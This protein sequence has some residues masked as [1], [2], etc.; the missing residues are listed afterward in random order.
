MLHSPSSP[1]KISM[2]GLCLLLL[3]LGSVAAYITYATAVRGQT[4]PPTIT[5]EN[6]P[7]TTGG[8]P[9]A[10]DIEARIDKLMAAMTIE[11]LVGQTIQA[12]ISDVTPADVRQYRLGAILNG[13]NSAP[14][15]DVRASADAWLALADEFYTASMDTTNGG[16]AIPILWGT[17]A[18]HGHNNIVGATVF[19]H[20]IGLGATRNP[21]LI[22]QIGEITAR[23]VIVT[24]MDWTFAPTLAVVRD[25]RW[26]RTYESYSEDPEIVAQYAAAM[27]TG[28][29]GELHTHSFLSNQHVIA[30]AKH[31]I[32][33]GGTQRGKD[34]GDNIDSETAL[35]DHHGAGYPPA[36]AAGVQTVM[37]SFSSWHGT[38]M[39]GHKAL[40]TDVLK[41]RMGFN[42]FVVGDWNGHAQI[43][44]CSTKSCPTAFNA[45]IDMFMAPDSWRELH[46]NT[47][48]QV[49]SGEIPRSRLDDAVR[50]IL[51]VKLRFL[52]E[53][54]KPS[55]R[56][57]AGNYS[58]LG[59]PNHQ[60]VARQAV[61]ESLVLLKNQG[62]LLP[63]PT[64]QT[65]LVTG[66][67]AHNIGK[68]SGGWTL[69]W[70]GTGNTNEHFPNG[71]S[72][73]EG[74]QNAIE[75]GG[76]QAVLS[77]DG[78]YDQTPDVAIVVFGEEPYAEFK[79]DLE[80]LNY[81]SDQALQLLQSFQAQ[82]IPTVAVFL[83]GRPLWVTPEI[84]AAD[85]FVAAWLPGS[86]GAG[87]ADVLLRKPNGAINVDFKGKLS[88]SWPRTATQTKVNQS[89]NYDP[90]FPYGYGLTYEDNGNVAKLPETSGLD[91]SET[92]ASNALF[93]FGKPMAPWSLQ[94]TVGDT[95]S[96]VVDARTQ[97]GKTLTIRAIDRAAQEDAQQFVWSGAG[98]I[99]LTGP[100]TDYTAA[101]HY[102]DMA[103]A[104]QYRVDALPAGPVT[105][106]A[107]SSDGCQADLDMTQ[108]FTKAPLGEW[109]QTEIT[110]SSLVEAGANMAQLTALGIKTAD[111]F[112]LSLSDIRLV[113]RD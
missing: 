5:P 67:G 62:N 40:L 2:L 26:G 68:Q 24:G 113:E 13:G 34:Q 50:R 69:S 29:Q 60:A 19:P 70:Q 77:A 11:E 58:L 104:I 84:N 63:L 15:E 4:M 72:I 74:M 28:L 23:E 103:L 97:L 44:G 99:A 81:S 106:L 75:A 35:R 110:L 30:T 73:W 85:A 108:L 93:A 16:K 88:F 56:P 83:S 8:A 39:H 3:V 71:T 96:T 86:A 42:G 41:D 61:R 52:F 87:V 89:G 9:L 7:T 32:G 53:K 6:W 64:H 47:V 90:L 27:V 1:M 43:P 33:D 94:A 55:E 112:S 18:V 80:N 31:F 95:S 59:H 22:Q 100:A 36:L 105:L 92:T 12:D 54:P 111:P 48:A 91:G 82:G 65:I 57:L 101:A 98:A 37:A 79:G 21:A 17:D 66:D 109:T 38:R 46:Q 20:N 49:K 76:G 51:R 107:K 102:N 10:A 78:S 45:G 25:N 14:G